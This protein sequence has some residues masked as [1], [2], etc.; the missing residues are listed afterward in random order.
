METNDAGT[1]RGEGKKPAPN[2]ARKRGRKRDWA[3]AFLDAFKQIGIV[4]P[5]ANHA[6]VSR[7]AVRMRTLRDPAFAKRYNEA[8]E[9][10]TERLEA[11][12]FARATRTE[13]PSDL[14]LMFMLKGRKPSIYRDNW[15]VEHAVA[16]GTAVAPVVSSMGAVILLPRDGFDEAV[17]KYADGT[18]SPNGGTETHSSHPAK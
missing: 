16:E 18:S 5:A 2:V 15:K 17:R 12:A 9:E 8:V 7:H 4:G 1:V 11:V 14:L 13:E 6:G 10:S 3:K